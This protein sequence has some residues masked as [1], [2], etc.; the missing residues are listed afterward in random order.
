MLQGVPKKHETWKTTRGPLTDILIRMKGPSI[1]TNARKIMFLQL[2]NFIKYSNRGQVYEQE[3][4]YELKKSVKYKK[5]LYY[6]KIC[7]L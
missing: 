1:K 3:R 7:H 2:L 4:T 6:K 5:K